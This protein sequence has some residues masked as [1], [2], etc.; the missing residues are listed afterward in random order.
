MGYDISCCG[1]VTGSVGSSA[2]GDSCN[3]DG[4]GGS[5][6]GDNIVDSGDDVVELLFAIVIVFLGI[7]V[8]GHDGF[9]VGVVIDFVVVIAVVDVVAVVALTNRFSKGAFE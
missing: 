5:S 1:N 9:I 7:K 8:V 6:A 4:S 2:G 3:G